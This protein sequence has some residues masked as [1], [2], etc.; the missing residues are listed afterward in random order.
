MKSTPWIWYSY[1]TTIAF[2]LFDYNQALQCQDIKQLRSNPQKCSWSS[3]SYNTASHIRGNIN[4]LQNE[5]LRFL[6]LQTLKFWSP[7]SFKRRQSIKN[8][9]EE[10]ARSRTK[11][12][13]EELDTLF[14]WIKSYRK[15]LKAGTHN[16]PICTIY[17]SVFQKPEVVNLM[18]SLHDNF[19]LVPTDKGS[20][21][22]VLVCK[23]YYYECLSDDLGFTST[24]GN[25]TY[26]ISNL[27]KECSSLVV[28]L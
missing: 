24:Y 23:D 5:D 8:S 19:V 2:K 3:F 20:I 10:Y 6:I 28:V 12:E 7:R 13:W 22:T 14:D 21:N 27:I 11:S 17:I 16:L 26:T 18:S 15:W 25:P 4:I 9:V 1:T